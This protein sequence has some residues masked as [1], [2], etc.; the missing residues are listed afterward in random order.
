MYYPPT[1]EGARPSPPA[2]LA[3]SI[4][5]TSPQ[6]MRMTTS[7]SNVTDTQP[8]QAPAMTTRGEAMRPRGGFCYEGCSC[9]CFN[10]GCISEG[11]KDRSCWLTC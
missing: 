7:P 2:R 8:V 4:S 5:S 1:T 6:T 11:C 9:C 10:C 3:P